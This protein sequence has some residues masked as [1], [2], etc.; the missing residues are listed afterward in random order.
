MQIVYVNVYRVAPL[1]G[2]EGYYKSPPFT[3]QYSCSHVF[4]CREVFLIIHSK[5]VLLHACNP[6][7]SYFWQRLRQLSVA[8]TPP[9]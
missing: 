7:Y 5:N 9:K 1:S 8:Y 6:G 3:V 4:Q 2:G